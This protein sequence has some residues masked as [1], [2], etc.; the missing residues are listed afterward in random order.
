[1]SA[2]LIGVEVPEPPALGG[3]RED[4]SA[5]RAAIL[6]ARTHDPASLERVFQRAAP[7]DRDATVAVVSRHAADED[8][9]LREA[10][11]YLLHVMRTEDGALSAAAVD[12]LV[13]LARDES[14]DVRDWALFALGRGGEGR[15]DGPGVRTAFRANVRHPNPRVRREAIEGLAQLGDVECLLHA[16]EEYDVEPETVEAAGRTR[17][18]RLLPALRA[19]GDRGWTATGGTVSSP[20]LVRVLDRAI[21][22][23]GG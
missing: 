15:T 8:Q 17:H 19:L 14:D 16:L 2:T 9:A 18:P 5:A 3:C 21:L 22:E 6:R 10:C 23:C 4:P 11:A 12:A 1:M 7:A 13:R 20:V